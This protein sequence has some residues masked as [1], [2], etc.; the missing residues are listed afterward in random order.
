MDGGSGWIYTEETFNI[1]KTGNATDAANWLLSSKYFLTNATTNDGNET[2]ESTTGGSETGH[3]G[4][5]YAKITF[6][7]KTEEFVEIEEIFEYTGDV[8]EW[9]VPITGAYQIEVWGAQGGE[10]SGNSTA[11]SGNGGYS[12]GIIQL[13]KD[14]K[15]Y[16]YVGGQGGNATS[17]CGGFNGGGIRL[18]TKTNLSYS[19]GGGGATDVR[20]KEDSLFARVIVAGRRRRSR[21]FNR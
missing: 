19:T 15:L 17:T 16:I 4:N 2:F 9:T 14:V 13:E 7:S 10:N 6:V 5:G 11:V 12:K 20:I 3:L 21:Y 1:W 18:G 8:Q